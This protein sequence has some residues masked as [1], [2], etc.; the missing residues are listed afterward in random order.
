MITEFSRKMT[1][2]VNSDV[3]PDLVPDGSE[4]DAGKRTGQAPDDAG[5]RSEA[6][7][8]A[9]N[10][11]GQRTAQ[12]LR[13]NHSE[14]NQGVSAG[15]QTSDRKPVWIFSSGVKISIEEILRSRFAGN[16]DGGI[17]DHFKHGWVTS[18]P[19]PSPS[20]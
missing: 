7:N 16:T 15:S 10:R 6:A 12:S 11:R 1:I 14:L 13:G 3:S 9:A 8:T 4:R 20:I 18:A 2:S 19:I 17:V 5:Q